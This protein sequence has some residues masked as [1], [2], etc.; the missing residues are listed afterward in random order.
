MLLQV[1]QEVNKRL[2]AAQKRQNEMGPER[3]S[4]ASQAAYLTALSTRFQDLVTRALDAKHGV[5]HLFEQHQALR[6]APTITNRMK[7][8]CD[9][10]ALSGHL[11]TFLKPDASMSDDQSDDGNAMQLDEPT[12]EELALQDENESKKIITRKVKEMLEVAD[13]ISPEQNLARSQDTG[14]VRWLHLVYETNRGFELGT[15]D[16]G[17]LTTTMRKQSSRWPALS[18]GFISDV[19]VVVHKFIT[20][21]L[22]SIC[23][24]RMIRDGLVRELSEGLMDRY[25]AAMRQVEFLLEIER[26][27]P[28][29]MNHYFNDNLEK[30]RGSRMTAD[31]AKRSIND[32]THGTVVR[33]QDAVTTH[34]M[35]N[36]KHTILDIHDILKSY[37]KVAR[38]RFV[39]NVC[40]QAADHFLVNGPGSPLRY[41][42]PVFVSQL[43]TQKLES[44]AGEAP[45]IKRMRAQLM[46]EIES[47]KEAKKIIATG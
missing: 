29:T 28:M 46:K 27:V 40:Q 44:I 34:P 10:M 33:L 3:N 30:S 26:G 43:S 11:Y 41:F 6:I 5:D 22:D 24:D 36:T 37:Y 31:M 1:Q 32:C 47:L 2:M 17:I 35:S 8:F 16:S 12:V 18:T 13:I 20:T 4:L 9:D 38:K 25:T 15:F 23:S 45:K 21:T 7:Q 42:S 39:D 14:I 19:I